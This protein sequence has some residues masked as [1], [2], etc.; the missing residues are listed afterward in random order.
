MSNGV[1]NSNINM[2]C[3]RYVKKVNVIGLK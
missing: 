2:K 1:Y 3:V